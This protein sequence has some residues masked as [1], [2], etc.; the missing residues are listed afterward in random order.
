MR[1]KSTNRF[2]TRHLE[3]KDVVRATIVR[4]EVLEAS[5][6]TLLLKT[7]AI[8]A[9]RQRISSADMEMINQFERSRLGVEM[10]GRLR[11]DLVSGD[12]LRVRYAEGD[13][14][15]ENPTAMVVGTLPPPAQCTFDL[16]TDAKPFFNGPAEL[17]ARLTITT[18]ALT[19]LVLLDPF[20]MEIRDRSGTLLCGIGGPEKNNFCFW[21][22]YNTGL[23]RAGAEGTPVAVESIDL[24][25]D[26]AVFGLGE[27]FIKL[28]KVGQTIDVNMDDTLGVITP[29]SYK[30]IPFF[31][32]THGFGVFFN[33][34]AQMTV[35]VGSMAATDV[36]VAVDDDFLDYFVFTGSIKEILARYAD[37]T[38][39][40][41]LPPKWSFGYWQSKLSYHTAVETLEV[42]RKMREA[43]LPMDV[44][45]LDTDWFRT[46]WLCDLV[47]DDERFHDPAGYIRQLNAL[48]VQ[49]SVWQ[50]PYLPEG[51]PLFEEIEA[52]DGFV[53]DAEGEIYNVH[54]CF[55][56]GFS[57]VVG[58]VDYTNPAAV[59]ILTAY[60]RRLFRLGVKVIKTDFGE[61]A[62][63]DGIYHD[64]TPGRHMHNAYPL[65]YN[66][67]VSQVTSEETGHGLVWAR[68]AWAGSQRYPV[69]WGGDSTPNYF[70]MTPQLEGGL[71]FGL[72]GFPFWSQDIG[73]FLGSSNDRLLTRWLQWGVFLSHARMH[74]T[75]DRELY[76]FAP[77]TVRICREFLNLRYRLLPYIY[78]MGARCVETALP[79]ARALVVEYQD[80][81]TTWN[82]GDQY[83]F[84]E[85]LLVAPIMDDGTRRRV[86]LPQ[87][88]WTDWWTHG[89]MPGGCWIEV[90]APLDR[91]P[92]YIREGGLIPLG[93]VQQ[94][95]DEQRTEVVDLLVSLYAG[96]GH[97]H[98]TIP[99]NDEWIPVDYVAD[100]GRHTL[101]IGETAVEFRVTVLGEGTLSVQ[102]TAG[103]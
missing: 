47:F 40:S 26:M 95:V 66:R 84:G 67:A 11:L 43:R 48:G 32:T 69:H 98:F 71:S 76:A 102:Q 89:R 72:C 3:T 59:D 79:M 18:E 39:K 17:G 29:R 103:V 97:T 50:L 20:R 70:N 38:G 68:S 27:K 45:H 51:T 88:V 91:M 55:T 62:P 12:V 87:G 83:L 53:K 37:L 25:P 85:S 77:E 23:C 9:M 100:A 96:S 73:G 33:H 64:G 92:L 60:F 42:V 19:V 86:Y 28:N 56:P 65:H 82:L 35:W 41:V 14:V 93:P 15:P 94:Y 10:E 34:Y 90:E 52:V 36:Q 57:G 31:L 46:P 99:V 74:G 80:D 2:I 7:T 58:V 49:L 1:T 22:S 24:F 63:S 54:I 101:T 30:N 78:G 4:A 75:G 16:Q 81:P 61:S 6:S 44:I 13:A 21:D 5:D 8:R